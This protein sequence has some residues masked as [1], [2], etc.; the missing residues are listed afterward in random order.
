[1]EQEDSRK[2]VAYRN[3]Q[4]VESDAPDDWPGM[5]LRFG[6]IDS[7]KEVEKSCNILSVQ[8]NGRIKF[9]RHRASRALV[10][11]IFMDGPVLPVLLP[12]EL[13]AARFWKE[14]VHPAEIAE[15]YGALAAAIQDQGAS[16][17]ELADALRS[18]DVG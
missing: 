8:L 18:S 6:A 11:A 3:G 1:M 12:T 4:F 7:E 13:D 17:A 2:A 9:F 14:F 5:I 15:N 16:F 10:A